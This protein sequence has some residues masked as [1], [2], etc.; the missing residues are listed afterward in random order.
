MTVGG[1]TALGLAKEKERLLQNRPA[2]VQEEFERIVQL[3]EGA[4]AR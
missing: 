4:A 2:I 3:L 1:K